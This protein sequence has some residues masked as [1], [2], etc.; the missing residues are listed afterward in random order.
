MTERGV[1]GLWACI[2]KVLLYR[3]NP[4]PMATFMPRMLLLV[5]S[6]YSIIR[7]PGGKVTE[8]LRADWV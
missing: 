6:P 2:M 5:T 4:S 7:D 8:Q 1:P 3:K